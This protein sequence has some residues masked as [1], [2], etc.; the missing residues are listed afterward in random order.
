MNPARSRQ[1]SGLTL[2]LALGVLSCSIFPVL[3]GCGKLHTTDPP[4]TATEQFLL[5]V[6][7]REAVERVTLDGLADQTVYV[8]DSRLKSY[9]YQKQQLV[10]QAPTPEQKFLV[11]EL[12]AKM[13]ERGAR[14]TDAPDKAAVVVEVWSGGIGIDRYETI[15]GVPALYF[16]GFEER[17]DTALAKTPEIAIYRRRWGLGVGEVAVAAYQA[18]TG[19]LIALSHP[20]VGFGQRKDV[21]YFF[22]VEKRT[23]NVPTLHRPD[24]E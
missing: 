15:V 14:L 19:E 18:G 20:P 3:P 23:G 22:V 2:R 7:A 5:S 6:S 1:G 12:R 8:D 11:G 21:R 10:E 24:L 9:V 16:T 17:I 13:L 4:R